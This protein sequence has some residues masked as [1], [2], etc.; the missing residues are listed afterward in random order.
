[1]GLLLRYSFGSLLARR[2]TATLTILGMALVVFVFA[3]VLM[4]AHGLEKT[5]VDTGSSD[6]VIVTRKAA[7]TETVSIMSRDQ[8]SILTTQGEVAVQEDGT[9]IA[10]KEIVVLISADK[11]KSGDAGNVIIRGTSATAF[12]LRPDVRLVEGR[13]F[14]P[15]TSEV[16]A[17]R[18]VARN[19]K[20]CGLGEKLKF[21]GRDWLV[22][23]VFDAGGTGFDSEL[24]GDADQV[25]QS[26]RRPIYS[27]VTMKLRE[28]ARFTEMKQRLEADP[29]LTI[30]VQ[31]ER[32]YYAKQSQA[33]ATFIKVIGLAVSILFSLGATIGAMITMFAAVA[34]RTVEIGTLRALGFTRATVLRVF[35]AESLL[36]GLLGGVIGVGAAS[37]LSVISVTT[38]NW[39]TFSEVAFGFVLSPGIAIGALVFASLMGTV[40]GFLPAV[41][42]AQSGIVDSLRAD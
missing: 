23:G 9:P 12:V 2:L 39:T 10:V 24:W 19:F 27:S 32:A 34:N 30:D 11:R 25:Q 28:P 8:A 7:N 15:G 13:M 4:L 3:A 14:A 6:N 17:G 37:L 21:A 35:L 41:R 31:R 1:V 26:F 22:V 18:S 16:I 42:A 38:T 20:G 29:R 5:L 36:L 33:S 40:G